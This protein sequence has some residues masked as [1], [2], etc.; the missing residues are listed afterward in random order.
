MRFRT[1]TARIRAQ[2]GA[3][4]A[5]I[6]RAHPMP[7]YFKQVALLHTNLPQYH[8]DRPVSNDLR[9]RKLA[10]RSSSATRYRLVA[11]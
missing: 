11:A 8:I 1:N 3:M 7:P 10:G 4:V 2:L 5:V 9:P 6:T